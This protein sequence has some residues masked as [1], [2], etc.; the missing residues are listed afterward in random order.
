MARCA[1]FATFIACLFLTSLL[2]GVVVLFPVMIA[3]FASPSSPSFAVNLFHNQTL[4]MTT[5]LTIHFDLKLKNENKA[6]GLHYPDQINITFSYF[7]NVSSLVIL[8]DY[9]LDSFY[10]GNGKTKHVRDVVE[11]VGFPR[12]LEG[13]DMMVFRVDL[14][15]SFRYKKVGTKRHKVELGCLVAVDSI[16]NNKMQRGFIRMVKPGLD[17][18]LKRKPTPHYGGGVGRRL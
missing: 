10:Q 15:G 17:S 2:L 11:A 7:P 6:I 1:S 3:L 8:A 16:T 9:K 5:N 18:K 14:M 13:T 4:N 12:V